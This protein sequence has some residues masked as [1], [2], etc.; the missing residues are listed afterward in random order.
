MP[1]PC[2]P[3]PPWGLLRRRLPA[4]LPLLAV[5]LLP[6]ALLGCAEEPLPERR[7]TREDCLREV[8]LDRLKEAIERCDKVVAAFPADPAPLNDRFLLHTLAGNEAAACRDVAR[9]VTLARK[10]PAKDLDPLLRNDLKLR[11]ASCRD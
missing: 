9:A 10:L 3:L 1:L 2:S 6:A 5:L 8:K 11:E 7:I 4:A